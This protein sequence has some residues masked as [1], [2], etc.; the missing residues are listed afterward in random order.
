MNKKTEKSR[1]N[2]LVNL[3][4]SV[5]LA[6]FLLITLAVTSIIGTVIPQGESMQFY[7]ERYGATGFRLIKNLQINDTYHS[8]WYLSLLG[9]FSLNLVVCTLKRLPYTIKLFTRDLLDVTPDYLSRMPN[10]HIW[11]KRSPGMVDKM[12]SRF[13]QLI[14]S[15]RHGGDGEKTRLSLS[16]SGRWSY[17]G[18]YGLHCS[19]LVIF[20]GALFGSFTGF[21]GRIMLLEGETTDHLMQSGSGEPVPLGFQ[22][23]CDNFD[24]SFYDTG[25][26]K[27][28]RSD[29]V[30][31]DGGREVL[32]KSIVVNDP[33]EYRGVTFYQSSYQPVSEV[34]LAITGSNGSAVTLRVPAF[35]RVPW[36]EAGLVVGLSKYIPNAHGSEAARIWFASAAGMSEPMWILKGSPKEFNYGGVAYRISLEDASERYF[37]GLQVKKDP[38]VWI[39]WFGCL[40]M[41]L[42]FAV[43]F[44]VAHRRMWLWSGVFN[45][46]DV[47]ILAGQ[48]NKNRMAFERDFEKVRDALN[49]TEGENS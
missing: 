16:E 35:E 42:G 4:S 48:A 17:W 27:E 24:V 29:L 26:P 45:G 43:V 33:L 28:F 37:T 49:E 12:F 31:I 40:A 7:L 14:G 21:K 22:L 25:A 6:V 10:R 34:T 38:G 11:K 19:I 46:E 41:V 18:I 39:V 20:A 1:G 9:L 30:V 2:P 3:L 5:K 47:V 44:W 8:W 36:K 15:V 23:R 13:E 32:K